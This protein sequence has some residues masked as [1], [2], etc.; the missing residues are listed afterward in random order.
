VSTRPARLALGLAAVTEI[1]HLVADPLRSRAQSR[2]ST[3]SPDTQA[4]I[5]ARGELPASD[6]E[7]AKRIAQA[8]DALVTDTASDQP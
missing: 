4:R 2:L 6:T 3:L 7:A 5:L 8:A 1:A